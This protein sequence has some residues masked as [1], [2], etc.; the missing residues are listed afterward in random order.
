MQRKAHCQIQLP[1]FISAAETRKEIADF[2]EALES[3]PA[4]AA[5]QPLLSFHQHLVT[6]SAS[7]RPATRTRRGRRLIG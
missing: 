2:L 1:Q 3:Y 5:E 4:R 7:R 6:I